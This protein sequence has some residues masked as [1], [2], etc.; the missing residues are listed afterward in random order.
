[1]RT[2][3]LTGIG[4]FMGLA[5]LVAGCGGTPATAQTTVQQFWHATLSGH[6]SAAAQ[7]TTNPGVVSSKLRRAYRLAS[8]E[9]HMTWKQLASARAVVACD[10]T[11]ATA[12]CHATF[13]GSNLPATFTSLRQVN[14]QWRLLASDFSQVP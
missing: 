1:M 11:G 5:W 9:Y 14:G 8:K 4:M 7:L 10:V 6:E 3:R 12:F 2:R 13:P